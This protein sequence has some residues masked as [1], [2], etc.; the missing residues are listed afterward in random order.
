MLTTMLF[1]DNCPWKYFPLLW[2]GPNLFLPWYEALVWS[3]YQF[4]WLSPVLKMDIA[5]VWQKAIH[6]F[7][8]WVM[9]LSLHTTS[10][11]SNP[12]VNFLDSFSLY[13]APRPKLCILY[14]VLISDLLLQRHSTLFQAISQII[15]IRNLAQAKQSIHRK[16][17]FAFLI[18]YATSLRM[19]FNEI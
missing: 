17:K 4:W 9:N 5:R 18:V 13:Q 19:G 15:Y 16:I 1:C 14:Q 2:S 7:L 11:L 6:L 8:I 10:Q 3:Y 12:R